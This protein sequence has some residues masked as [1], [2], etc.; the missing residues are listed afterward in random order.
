[1]RYKMYIELVEPPYQYGNM[2]TSLKPVQKNRLHE[3]IITQIQN[4]IFLGEIKDGEKLPPERNL[5]ETFNVNRAT[6]R[7]AL[8]K[9]EI[10]GLVEI[11]HGDGIY[12]KDYLKSG[13]LDLIKEMAYTNNKLN[14]SVIRDLLEVR[15]IFVPNMA[16]FAAERRSDSDISYMQQLISDAS[17]PVQEKDINFHFAIARSSKNLFY[18][19]VHNFFSQLFRDFG[20]LYFNN[21][22]NC[23]KSV[24]FHEE[25]FQA[26]K[27]KKANEAQRIMKDILY[28]AESKIFEY[29]NSQVKTNTR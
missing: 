4:K 3:E 24:S 22:S 12:A 20:Y 1:M 23:A 7:E 19:F 18:I 27:D 16:F 26:I 13:N 2:K 15:N 28:Y 29:Y 6:V 11:R 25:I 8:K 10:L 14:I 5:A 17:M 9:L 21:E